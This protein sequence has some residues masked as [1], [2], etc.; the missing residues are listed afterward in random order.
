MQSSY[1][2]EYECQ[3]EAYGEQ[4]LETDYSTIAIDVVLESEGPPMYSVGYH[5]HDTSTTNLQAVGFDMFL[6]V[7]HKLLADLAMHGV[8]RSMLIY[9]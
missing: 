8:T 9:P 6:Q 3:S 7:E 2:F 4:G 1:D 5:V